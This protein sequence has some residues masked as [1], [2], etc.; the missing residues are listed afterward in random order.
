MYRPTLSAL[1]ALLLPT[2]SAGALELTDLPGVSASAQGC[3]LGCGHDKYDASNILDGDYGATG[4]T[5]LNSWNYGTYAGWVQVDLADAYVLDRVELYG[6]YAYYNPFT[7]S[8]SA[9]GLGWTTVAVGGYGTEPDL[10]Q[11]GVAGIKYG[12]VL[13][14]ADGSMASG[15]TARYVRYTVNAGSPH[16][17]YLVEMDVQGHLPAAPVPEPETWALMLAGLG[18]VGFV[19]RRRRG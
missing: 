19:A 14:V 1:L 5:G 11:T 18:L 7:L 12:A 13:D 2:A 9:D 17:G 10:S 8:V 15:L 3:Y 6:V 4:N 16:W